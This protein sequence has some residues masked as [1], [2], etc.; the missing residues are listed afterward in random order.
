VPDKNL[1]VSVRE[2]DATFGVLHSRP[3]RVGAL[4][5]GT[6]LEDRPHFTS[7]STFRTVP[8]PTGL[9][10]ADTAGPTETLDSGV[11]LPSVALDRRAAASRVAE[12]ARRLDALREGWLNPPEWVERVPE[13]VPGYPDRI[14]PKPEHATDLKNR[15]LTNLYNARPTWLDRA[16]KALDLA[17][18]S[19]HGWDDYRPEIAEEEILRRRLAL[20]LELSR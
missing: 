5:M 16:H 9:T 7:S 12:A 13:V 14:I 1:V 19:A 11:I 3:H 8:F 17:V 20:N 4:K 15:T 6:S 10:P 2:D 18:A